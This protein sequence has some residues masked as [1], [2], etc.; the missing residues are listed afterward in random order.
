M[1]HAHC[2]KVLLILLAGAGGDLRQLN[3]GS[4]LGG[5][6][7]LR[8]LAILV[9]GSAGAGASLGFDDRGEKGSV[10][11]GG[12][13]RGLQQGSVRRRKQKRGQRIEDGVLVCRNAG[14]RQFSWRPEASAQSSDVNSEQKTLRTD[15][16]GRRV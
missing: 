9:V 1:Q 4:E 7:F 5:R 6:L 12:N 16:I 14:G 10:A 15:M 13:F 2:K 8:G 3:Q 11:R